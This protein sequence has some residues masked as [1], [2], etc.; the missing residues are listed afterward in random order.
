MLS[1]LRSLQ[2]SKVGTAIVALFFILILIG[3]ASTGVTNFGSGTVGFGMTSSTLAQVGNQEVTEQEMSD[4]MQRRLQQVRQQQPEASYATV[5]GDFEAILGELLDEKTLF[6]FADKFHFPLSKRL[7]DAEIAQI[8]QTKGL[9][10]QF[11]EQNYQGFL[12]QQRM[13]DSQIRQIL[14]GGLLERY[15]VTPVAANARISAG[16]ATPYA[17]MLLESREGEAAIVPLGAFRAGLKPTDADLQKYYTANRSR[18]MVPEQRVL[19]IARI[20][21]EQIANLTASDQEVAAY[22]NSHKAEYA[23]KETRDISQA[24]VQDEA[25][26]NGIAARAKGGATIAAAA[27]PVG[28]NAAVTTLKDQSRDA[29]SSVAGDKAAA[30]VFAAPSGTVVGPIQT[31]FGWA[32]AKI[33]SV[34]TIGGKSMEQTRAEIASKIT[35]DKRKGAIEDLV[36]KVQ[37]AVDDGSNFAEAAASA[38]LS[39]TTTPLIAADGTAR[40][41]PAF[42]LPPELAPAVKTGFELE[43]NDPPEIVTLPKDQGYAMVSPGQIISAAPAP[44]ANV[45][46]QVAKDWI[47]SQALQRARAAATQ[48]EA[49][50]AHGTP[51][52]QA[53]KESGTPL[54][55][56]QPLAARRIQLA[57]AQGPVPPGMKLLFSLAEGKSRMLPD[58]QGHGFFIVKVKKIV[59]GNALMQPS[60]IGQMQN[61]LQQG[62]SED[63]AREFLAALRQDLKVKRN[64]TAIQGMKSRMVSSGG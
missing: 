15:L 35:A 49:K 54:P 17:A 34:K 61:E 64:E 25:T 33:D 52:A 11:S 3:F 29:Y 10:G 44:F 26:A 40:S 48:I 38:K 60:L 2:K 30:A 7:V 59:P 63:Y 50:V 62:I 6:A 8:P 47:D 57:M 9:N 37:N 18:Y 41:D 19:R 22:Y 53:L 23:S 5:I 31:D 1:S 12:A 32:V 42:K 36:D 55:P 27:G 28:A 16:M 13:T 45:H 58:P 56:V 39:V 14:G 20:G 46:D 51:L 43:A 21:A 4:A 24:V